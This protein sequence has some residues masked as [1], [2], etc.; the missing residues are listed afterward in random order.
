MIKAGHH[1]DAIVLFCQSNDVFLEYGLPRNAVRKEKF[2]AELS[3]VDTVELT[4]ARLE[5]GAEKLCVFQN[6]VVREVLDEELGVILALLI[7]ASD[8]L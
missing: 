4:V 7:E 5:A 8:I 2:A 1:D 3:I 6:W